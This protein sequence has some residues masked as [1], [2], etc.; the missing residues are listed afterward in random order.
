MLDQDTAHALL[1][2]AD[3]TGARVAFIGDRHQL[4][5][6]GRGG[7]LDHA[8]AWA[9]PTAVVTLE[10]VHRFT[11]PD[12]AA[13]SLR[14]RTG[15]DPG[16]VFDT[17]HRRGQVVIHPSE[18]ERTT[19]LADLGASGEL[20]IAETRDQVADLNAAIRDQRSG[21]EPRPRDRRSP[22]TVARCSGS[23]TGSRPAATTPTCRWPTGRPGPSPASGTTA[24]S[25]CTVVGRDRADTCRIRQPV[26]RA[27]LR[28]HRPRRPG[29]DRRPRPLRPRGHHRCRGG[30]RRDDPRPRDQHR[31]PGRRRPRRGPPTMGRRPSAAT[32]PTSDPATPAPAPSTTSTATAPPSH[33][34]HQPTQRV[35]AASR[36]RTPG[37]SPDADPHRKPRNRPLTS[38]CS[39]RIRGTL[40]DLRKRN[41]PPPRSPAQGERIR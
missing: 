15:Q 7:V 28:H 22:P 13:L 3:E 9:H 11:D 4:P 34:V 19:A 37:G 25:S 17:L 14:M 41:V 2:I 31:P 23:G 10:K 38:P 21:S 8:V 18:A 20:V 24:A 16:S 33:Q 5:A 27:R 1:T 40:L 30:L 29:R 12:Y 32:A 39:K 36:T 6:V 35:T 26:R